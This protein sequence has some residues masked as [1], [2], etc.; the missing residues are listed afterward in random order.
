MHLDY[1][2][3]D[4]DTLYS[5]VRSV[6]GDAL[7]SHDPYDQYG[8]AQEWRFAAA[9]ALVFEHGVHV[10]GFRPAC[11]GPNRDAFAYAYTQGADVEALQYA[12]KILTR[13]V[14]WLIMA[15]EDY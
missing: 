3:I 11:S 12:F 13:F 14:D 5:G 6:L 2:K 1:T 7:I 8:W 4:F 10:P 9:D 15:G